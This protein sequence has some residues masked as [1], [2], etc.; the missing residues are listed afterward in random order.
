VYMSMERRRQYELRSPWGRGS[1]SKKNHWFLALE[2][3]L[4]LYN[5]GDKK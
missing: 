3:A 1:I 5:Y 4:L 2:L